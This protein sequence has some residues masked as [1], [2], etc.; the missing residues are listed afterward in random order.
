MKNW[1]KKLNL[2]QQLLVYF[3]IIMILPLIL[4][5]SIIYMQSANLLEKQAED[6]LGQ[7]VSNV[8]FHSDRFIKDYELATL[9]LVSNENVKYFLDLEENNVE[10]LTRYEYYQSIW[11]MMNQ[12]VMQNPEIDKMYIIGDNGRHISL[13]NEGLTASRQEKYNTMKQVAPDSGKV[14]I[15]PST[16]PNGEI[17]ITIARKIRGMNS[18]SPKG[19]LAI[20]MSAT[21]LGELWKETNLGDE[22]FFLITDSNGRVIYHPDVSFVGK[23]F[24]KEGRKQLNT[25]KQGSFFEEWDH[26]RT[27]FHFLTSDYTNW[28]L[29]AAVPESQLYEPISGVRVTAFISA[30]IVLLIAISMSV[31]FINQ[32]VQPI[33]LVER[34]MKSV[35]KGKWQKL[36][37]IARDDEISSLLNS[38]NS[39]VDRLSTLVD[40]VY[41]AELN[42]KQVKIELQERELEKQKV[43]IQALQSQINPH[44]LYNTLE[45]MGAYGMINGID[46]ISEMADSLANMFRYSVRNL[47]VVTLA[48]E[49]EHIKNY[50]VI[51]EHR[52]KKPINLQLEIAPSLYEVPM[53]KLSLQ[54]LIENAIEHGIQKSM[55]DMTITIRTRT[56]GSNLHVCVTDNGRGMTKEKLQEINEHISRIR[57]EKIELGSDLGIGMTNVNRRIQ[58]IF[59]DQYGLN[60]TSIEGEG[61]TVAITI[62][63][64]RTNSGMLT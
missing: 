26:E 7:V 18:Y 6:F 35:E 48:D 51:H 17:T 4:V 32:I 21:Q 11:S 5:A 64:Q 23:Q 55:K 24:N 29:I 9:P 59:G 57:K 53:V 19:I 58:L 37:K 22:G 13:Y 28:K 1:M 16:T 20:E 15:Y 39:M 42:N 50:L 12:I 10:E 27:F 60:L 2:F 40:Q 61:T 49:I 38:Y 47:E 45:T 54:P 33:R 56:N 8:S 14:I 36:P 31:N 46:E 41:K 3:A 30:I 52:N 43:E 34:T 63:Y 62:P 25:S 44:F